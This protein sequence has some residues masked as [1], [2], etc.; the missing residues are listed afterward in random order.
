[1]SFF[2]SLGSL[3]IRY[4]LDRHREPDV[5]NFGFKNMADGQLHHVRIN[6][7]AAVMFVESKVINSTT[8][9]VIKIMMLRT[10]DL[11]PKFNNKS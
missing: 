4:K 6:R 5:F 7:E 3:Q 11:K 2:S 9:T 8:A 10:Y 1:M